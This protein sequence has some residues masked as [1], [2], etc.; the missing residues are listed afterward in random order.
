MDRVPVFALGPH[1]AG[2]SSD[3]RTGR[4]FKELSQ[5]ETL[6]P[7]GARKRISLTTLKRKV[8]RF[9]LHG[10]DGLRRQSRTDRGG[11][12]KNREVIFARAIELK[13]EQPFRSPAAIN[14]ILKQEFG[15]TIPRS[16]MMRHLR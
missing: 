2:A 6:L 15:R 14:E 8:R 7:N 9:R 12:R 16:T 3:G 5:K 1:P 11:A 10:I 13:K 4:F